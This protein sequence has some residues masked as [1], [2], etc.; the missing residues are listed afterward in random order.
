MSDVQFFPKLTKSKQKELSHLYF[1]IDFLIT[2]M[3]SDANPMTNGGANFWDWGL[4]KV[5]GKEFPAPYK[6]VG[7]NWNNEE[8]ELEP[9]YSAAS[10]LLIWLEMLYSYAEKQD[11]ANSM[12]LL[13]CSK[14]FEWLLALDVDKFRSIMTALKKKCYENDAAR[15]VID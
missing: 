13:Q 2:T 15:R 14:A 5:E 9:E 12:M 7:Y 4:I 6:H 1:A 3:P 8:I 11:A 10:N